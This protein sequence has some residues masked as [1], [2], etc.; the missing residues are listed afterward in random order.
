MLLFSNSMVYSVR[1]DKPSKRNEQASL[2]ASSKIKVSSYGAEAL[3]ELMC[4]AV[5]LHPSIQETRIDSLVISP[6]SSVG[7]SNNCSFVVLTDFSA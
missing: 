2:S 5:T 3:F 1:D 7:I 6:A 4:N